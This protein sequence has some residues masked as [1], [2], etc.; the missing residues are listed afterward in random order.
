MSSEDRQTI[1]L[2]SIAAILRPLV[3]VLLRNGISYGSFAELSKRIYVEVAGQEG[4]LPGKKQTTSRISTIT[5]LTRKEV[6]RIKN[7][8]GLELTQNLEQYN[9]AARVITGWLRDTEFHN[10]KGQPANLPLDGDNSFAELVN[11]Y[12]G[13]I[14]MRAIA[15]ELERVE[16]IEI[17]NN[18]VYLRTRAY[19]PGKDENEKLKIL[20]TDVAD[21]IR[22]IDHNI[23]DNSD[24]PF[25]QRKVSYNNIPVAVLDTLRPQLARQAQH[26]LEQMDKLLA[27][28]DRD[29]NP[30]QQG[31]GRSRSGVAIYYFEEEIDDE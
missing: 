29:S 24:T 31:T 30:Q 26:S 15:D 8:S 16:A 22:T 28:H 12:S 9:R 14:P 17:K 4:A 11:R 21:L 2:R 1:L 10:S 18:R 7:E 25:F 5:G 3:R 13:D 27:Q 20:G 6:T 19:L 23:T